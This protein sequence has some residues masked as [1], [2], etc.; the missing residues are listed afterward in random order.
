MELGEVTFNGESVAPSENKIGPS[1]IITCRGLGAIFTK[2]M[3]FS[4]L[5]GP[6]LAIVIFQTFMAAC[7]RAPGR[8]KTSGV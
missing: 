6:W 5:V 2:L 1:S 7:T 3:K 4:A 8:M